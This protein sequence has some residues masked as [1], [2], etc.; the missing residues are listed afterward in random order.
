MARETV[1]LAPSGRH[2]ALARAVSPPLICS[3]A[4]NP[5]RPALSFLTSLLV[6][7]T[8]ISP[9]LHF[10]VRRSSVNLLT[11]LLGAFETSGPAV[12]QPWTV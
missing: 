2:S 7:V 12:T 9:N 10:A 1:L 6:P 11:V 5:G 8:L 3:T 4:E